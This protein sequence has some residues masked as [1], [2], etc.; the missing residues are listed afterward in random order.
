MLKISQIIKK[1]QLQKPIHNILTNFQKKI[2]IKNLKTEKKKLK[3]AYKTL[4]F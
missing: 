3:M 1:K 4:T 2:I